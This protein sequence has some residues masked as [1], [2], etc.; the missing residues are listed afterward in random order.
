MISVHRP[1]TPPYVRFRIRRFLFWVPCDIRTHER[2][3]T[4]IVQSQW[5][6][7]TMHYWRATDPPISLNIP[8]SSCIIFVDAT[9]DKVL[10]S[11]LREFPSFPYTHAYSTSQPF[12]CFKQETF[13]TGK[14]IIPDPPSYVFFQLLLSP[15][16]PPSIAA[17]CQFFQPWLH[18]GFGL[19][20]YCELAFA[21]HHIK[22]VA[23]VFHSAH[24][25]HYSL[26][27][28]DFEI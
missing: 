6:S 11:C 21:F 19:W 18:L 9:S 26:F 4:S 28:V 8:P 17:T 20:V 2:W 14:V 15:D 5:G 1:L 12:V 27:L 22:G 10:Y 7:C 3:I 25:R 13:H 24:I 16:I 23:E